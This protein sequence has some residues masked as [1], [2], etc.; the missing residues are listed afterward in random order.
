ME[1]AEQF[2]IGHT[3]ITICTDYCVDPD[4]VQEILDRIAANA[5]PELNRAS[6]RDV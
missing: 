3:K 2:M 6:V 5:L 1:I 4:R